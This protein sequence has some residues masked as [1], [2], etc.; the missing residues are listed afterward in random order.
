M[1]TT[2]IPQSLNEVHTLIEQT[3]EQA[4]AIIRPNFHMGLDLFLALIPLVIALFIFR[5]KSSMPGILW[6][7]LLAIMVLFLPNAPYVL[8][9]VIHFVA[10][11]RV[12]PPLPIWAMSLLLLEYFCYFLIGMESFVIPMMLWG[13]TLRRH[14]CGWLILPLELLIISLSA[15]GIYLGRIDRLNS[16]DVVTDPEHLM[17]QAL[18]DAMNPKPEEMTLL[19]FFAVIVVFYLIKTVNVLIARLL[20]PGPDPSAS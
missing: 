1:P 20:A 17:S 18:R 12:T 15:F 5:K 2:T 13:R 11:V 19:F 7:P 6:W 8:T 10:K 3:F 14:R 16:W 4:V 9:D